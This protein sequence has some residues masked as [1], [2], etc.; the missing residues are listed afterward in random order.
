MSCFF[1]C[2]YPRDGAGERI[3]PVI[4]RCKREVDPLLHK[5]GIVLVPGIKKRQLPVGVVRLDRLYAGGL[6]IA[7]ST[8]GKF[9]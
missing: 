4:M 7:R 2:P 9:K 5:L 1:L 3:G 8:D 6:L